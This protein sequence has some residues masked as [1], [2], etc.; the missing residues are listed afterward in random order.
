MPGGLIKL[1]GLFY[2]EDQIGFQCFAN[3]TPTRKGRVH[4]MHFN[5]TVIHPDYV[6]LGL[7]I[8]LIEATSEIMKKDGYDVWGKFSSVPVAKALERSDNWKL[9]N[10]QRF[11]GKPGGNMLRDSGF[12]NA[13]KTYSY[14]YEPRDGEKTEK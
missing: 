12:R 8:K 14:H 7:G 6:G 3:Y 1:F 5:R 2:K 13:V 9:I 10:V 11:Q 4:K